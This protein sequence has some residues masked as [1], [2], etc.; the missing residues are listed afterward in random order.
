MIPHRFLQLDKRERFTSPPWIA[1]AREAALYRRQ[2][3]GGAICQVSFE[4]A[5]SAALLRRGM[6]ADPIAE[7]GRMHLN[8]VHKRGVSRI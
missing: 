4:V 1:Y 6:H 5:M 2:K 8:R 3:K 7:A